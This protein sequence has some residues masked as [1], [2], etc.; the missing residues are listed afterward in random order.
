MNDCPES[1]IRSEPN[2]LEQPDLH[3]ENNYLRKSHELDLTLN[4]SD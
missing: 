1:R 3:R 2:M 4:Q